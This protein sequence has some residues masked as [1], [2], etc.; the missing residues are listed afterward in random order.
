VNALPARVLIIDDEAHARDR[1]RALLGASAD[2]VVV[3]ECA[4]GIAAV[5]AI[6]RERPSLITLDVQLP[7]L[8]G[9]AVLG[10]LRAHEMPVTIFVTA[11][12]E[13]AVRAFDL[14]AAD[15]VLKPIQ[16]DRF[17]LALTRALARLNATH[18]HAQHEVDAL[19][20]VRAS[21][22]FLERLGIEMRDGM[23]LIAVADVRWFEGADNYVRVHV[24]SAS[25]VLR[26]TMRA[27]EQQLDPARFMRVHRSAIVS[28]RAVRRLE[29]GAHGEGKLVLDDGTT[30]RVARTRT[31]RLRQQWLRMRA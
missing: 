29:R 6:R 8:D 2:V 19:R 11:Y 27:L 22:R 21:G 23:Q 25:Y 28:L 18:V 7:G 12:D 1:V 24:G 5:T 3:G 17:A 26:I 4:D 15:Y 30:V 20:L 9:F 13:H 10:H 14:G 31:A 16:A